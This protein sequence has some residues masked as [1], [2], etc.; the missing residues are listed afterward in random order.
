MRGWLMTPTCP[1]SS[2]RF[3]TKFPGCR[4][5]MIKSWLLSWP[6]F[7]NCKDRDGTRY[8][9]KSWHDLRQLP[10]HRQA[11]H[12]QQ[13]E[14]VRIWLQHTWLILPTT[15]CPSPSGTT[16]MESLATDITDFQHTLQGGQR[17][18]QEGGTRCSGKTDR[19]SLQRNI[20]KR[21]LYEP[22]LLCILIYRKALAS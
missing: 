21:R 9:L 2:P 1:S 11:P 17:R 4:A 3:V 13:V 18:G 10:S 6:W 19:T 7:L 22:I 8:S 20:F 5:T 12:I 16:R 14:Q 15:H